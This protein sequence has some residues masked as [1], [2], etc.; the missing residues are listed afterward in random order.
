MMRFIGVAFRA[1]DDSAFTRHVGFLR[2]ES[3]WMIAYHISSSVL[4]SYGLMN[5]LFFRKMT[6]QEWFALLRFR[7]L[8]YKAMFQWAAP[9]LFAAVPPLVW[10]VDLS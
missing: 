10:D 8:L 4:A 1:L 6:I 2:R 9:E 3:R 5:G 7:K